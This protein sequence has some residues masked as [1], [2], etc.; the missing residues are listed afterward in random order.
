MSNPIFQNKSNPE[1]LSTTRFE[2][3]T[4]AGWRK[5]ILEAVGVRL[6]SSGTNTKSEPIV[7]VLEN[8]SQGTEAHSTMGQSPVTATAE[9]IKPK[10]VQSKLNIR[11]SIGRT[12]IFA[13]IVCVV[14]YILFYSLRL[15]RNFPMIANYLPWPVAYSSGDIITWKEFQ[16]IVTSLQENGSL[17]NVS[18]NNKSE[19]EK[20]ALTTWLENKVVSHELAGRKVVIDNDQLNRQFKNLEQGFSS[21]LE[22]ENY[23]QRSYQMSVNEFK[24]LV[25]EPLIR[26]SM[27]EK[28]LGGDSNSLNLALQRASDIRKKNRIG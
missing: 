25:L 28:Q 26:R 4:I 22:F 11:K 2:P 23:L 14:L 10:F 24:R 15:D 20:K 7:P 27:L 18:S 8:T 19:V 9:P 6:V 17:L 3:A 21:N 16:S 5:S 12:A 1:L 13:G